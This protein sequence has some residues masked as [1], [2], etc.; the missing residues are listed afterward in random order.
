[1]RILTDSQSMMLSKAA[2]REDGV[3]VAPRGMNK[4]AAAKVGSSLVAQTHAR[5]AVKAGDVDLARRK[6]KS[7]S[8]LRAPAVMRSEL[9]TIRRNPIAP[10]PRRPALPQRRNGVRLMARLALA[11]SKL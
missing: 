3:A 4:A 5:N 11:P 2:A 8:S 6:W 1:M 9:K 10:P 7:T